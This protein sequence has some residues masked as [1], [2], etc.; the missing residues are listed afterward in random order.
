MGN[1]LKNEEN[2]LKR[3]TTKTIMSKKD[4][5]SQ[6]VPNIIFFAVVALIIF[7]L[8]MATHIRNAIWGDEIVILLDIMKKSPR[9]ARPHYILGFLYDEGGQV[10][11]A[12]R[13][14]EVALT[15][16]PNYAEA[17]NNLGVAYFKKGW[18]DKAVER[19]QIAIRLD[20]KYADA[21]NNLGYVYNAKGWF[22]KAIEQY[23][24]SLKLQSDSAET[25]NNLGVAYKNK[26][27]IDR[28]IGEYETALR[29]QPNPGILYNLANVYDMK[30]LHDK[31][32]ET[33]RKAKVLEEEK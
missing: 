8:S 10:D 15:L 2:F 13:E 19:F 16:D 21:Y 28:A 29:I 33:R 22:D 25:R 11:N 27:W 12:I 31:A 3:A 23:E 20:S 17:H 30:G 4:S 5:T 26:G 32:E 14:F 7:S 18:M 1:F 6:E 9:K 24:M